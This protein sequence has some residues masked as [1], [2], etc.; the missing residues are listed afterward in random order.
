MIK[1]CVCNSIF[2]LIAFIPLITFINSVFN[3]VYS[4]VKRTQLENSFHHINDLHQN[5]KFTMEDESNGGLAFLD[6]LL[7][8]NNR[9]ISVLLYR[10][11]R[12][13]D[14]YLC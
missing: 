1:K 9:K 4:I 13:T 11:P 14:Q 6:T 7:K 2:H 5:I 10:T 12:H 3:C 8:Q